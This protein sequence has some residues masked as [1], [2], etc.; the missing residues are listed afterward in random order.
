MSKSEGGYTIIN[1]EMKY[2]QFDGW[3]KVQIKTYRVFHHC[4]LLNWECFRVTGATIINDTQDLS[5]DDIGTQADLFEIIKIGDEYFTYVTSEKTSA[6]T[7]LLR[8]PSKVRVHTYCCR[9]LYQMISINAFIRQAVF[10]HFPSLPFHCMVCESVSNC[11]KART[12]NLELFEY[13]NL[14]LAPV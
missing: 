6:V 10:A 8:G 1:L 14:S 7:V 5:E 4:F 9:H 3:A 13:L 2:E 12:V 11:G